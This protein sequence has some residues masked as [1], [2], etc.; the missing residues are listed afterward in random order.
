[1]VAINAVPSHG[2]TQ[3]ESL[4]PF[5]LDNSVF[6]CTC[7]R[8]LYVIVLA[9]AILSGE[10]PVVDVMPHRDL[11]VITMG[12]TTVSFSRYVELELGYR[13]GGDQCCTPHMGIPKWKVASFLRWVFLDNSVLLCTCE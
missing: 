4:L 3:V 8:V 9:N 2:Y 12:R 7:E 6:L 11:S 10:V 1:M 5:F 13:V